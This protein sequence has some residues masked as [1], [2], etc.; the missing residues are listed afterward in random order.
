MSGF[1]TVLPIRQQTALIYR[2][3]LE[4]QTKAEAPRRAQCTLRE[5]GLPVGDWAT[6]MLIGQ[7]V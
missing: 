3:W 7:A 1:G 2:H 6:H 4:G 5:R